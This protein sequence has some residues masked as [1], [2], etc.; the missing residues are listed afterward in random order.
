[1][2]SGGRGIL[3]AEQDPDLQTGI[4]FVAVNEA[5][6]AQVFVYFVL[7]PTGLDAAL[8][9]A[10]IGIRCVGVQT[11]A[12]GLVL[13][14][15]FAAHTDSQ[16]RTREV[17]AI[18]FDSGA[19]FEEQELTLT[20]LAG[21]RLDPFS[22][23]A[24][25]SF[26]QSCP[27]VFDC[28]C[29]GEAEPRDLVDFPVDYLA[30]DFGTFNQV[31]SAFSMLRYPRWDMDMPADQAVMLKEVIAALGDEFAYIQDRYALETQFDHLQDRRS[32]EQLTR[33]LGYRLAPERPATGLVV[34]RHYDGDR[35]P[36]AIAAEDFA[37]ADVTD[38]DV[39]VTAGTRL[40]GY[41]DA[42]AVITFEIGDNLDA[43]N[44]ARTWLTNAHWTDIPAHVPDPTCAFARKGARSLSVRGRG[45]VHPGIG[46][47]SQVVIETRPISQSD[48]L[49]RFLVTLDQDPVAETD[50][51]LGVATTRLHW[52]AADALAFDLALRECYVSANL[53]P[54][55]S[56]QTWCE[57]FSIG[58]LS[59]DIPTAIE[60]EG[61]KPLNDAGRPVL[62]RFP[63][64]M[65]VADGL[66]WSLA[67]TATAW[68]PVHQ[69][70][71]S[72]AR[73]AMD[74]TAL[75]PW[76][77]VTDML[78]QTPTDE[79]ATVEPGHWG[80]I[81]SYVENG[82]RKTH[83][84][85]I[86]DPGFCLRFGTGAF[87]ILPARG[88]L[89]EVRYRTAWASAANLPA[90][91]LF[92]AAHVDETSASA[93]RCLDAP[94]MPAQI[95]SCWNPFRFA[96]AR[97][98]ENIALAKLTVPHFHKAQ[99]L[100]AVRNADFQE[101]I[102]ARDDIDATIATAHWTGCW[103][104]NFIA[105]DPRDHIGLSPPLRA[106]VQS[107]IE[108]I[109]LVGRPAYLTD[110]ALRPIDLRIAICHD[111]RVPFGHIV[112]ALIA[113]LAGDSPDA[114]F[115][116]NNLS[117]GSALF[118]ADLESRIAAQPGVT[119]IRAIRYRWR[120]EAD[121]TPFTQTALLSA[122]DQIPILRHDATR[123]DLGRIEVFDTAIP[124]EAAS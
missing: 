83:R 77:V 56:G 91:R 71:V 22:R 98:A 2:M 41:G 89:F 78:T 18:T 119:A 33:I 35:Q 21:Q 50:A 82:T 10:D 49:R 120:G 80:P 23:T 66:A 59:E 72:L 40:Y 39:P 43:I 30:R 51:L 118:R 108:E 121:F 31:F 69:P 14:Q 47:G 101:L 67:D 87:G 60:R 74:G 42:G 19:S 57:R 64:T 104:A 68:D 84:D 122:A 70:H 38:W 4:D 75:A 114:L 11:R 3:L 93:A 8:P 105:V 81:L 6:H 97:P 86:G 96:D 112:E 92:L 12:E 61:P 24:R 88:S 52:R 54:V 124:A 90:N 9:A 107:F 46:A 99:K 116:P 111:P 13:A 95:M 117:F 58:A 1:M 94:V 34:L 26:K 28:A 110:A 79:A 17:L 76:S 65:T 44:A 5:D 15:D 113:D 27:T 100:R 45:L 106:E 123:P 20:D 85:Y 32:F 48:P 7:D 109:R 73:I 37:I 62:Y 115:H 103:A 63:L 36:P 29:Y 102:S 25:F 55:M 16:G 53:V